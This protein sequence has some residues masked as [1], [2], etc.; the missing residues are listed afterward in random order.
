MEVIVLKKL[1][2]ILGGFL[3][4][5]FSANI[6]FLVAKESKSLGGKKILMII[7]SKDFRDEEY[8]VPR[9]ILSEKGAKIV[10]AST[11]QNKVIGMLG[12]EVKPDINIK[13]AQVKDYNAI[14]FVGGIGA[15]E[16]WNSNDAFKIIK[17]AVKLNKVIAAIC[18]A[19][20]TLA[21]SGLLKGKK[22]TVWK[23]ESEKLQNEGMIY[24]DKNVVVDGNIITADGPSSA[25]EFALVI[26]EQLEKK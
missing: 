12:T 9:K 25:E 16:Y 7:A 22:A 17:D 13:K 3:L 4:L 6:I 26:A 23:S 18:I 24:V 11:T 8:Q 19:P 14:I 15:S 20:V 10:V 21:K 2:L 5:L 1:S